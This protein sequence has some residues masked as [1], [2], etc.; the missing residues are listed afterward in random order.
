M[1]APV[2]PLSRP[3]PQD[4]GCA[5]RS[6]SPTVSLSRRRI[7]PNLSSPAE[8]SEGKGTQVVTPHTIRN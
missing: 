1:T 6:N 5:S 8:R 7:S 2:L 4:V 3:V